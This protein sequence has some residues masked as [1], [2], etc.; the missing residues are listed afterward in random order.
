MLW[1]Y[2]GKSGWAGDVHHAA[3]VDGRDAFYIVYKEIVLNT[4]TV[5]PVWVRTLHWINAVAVISG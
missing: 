3:L 1:R 2:S 4:A 5:H